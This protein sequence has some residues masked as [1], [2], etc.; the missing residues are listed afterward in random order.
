M[1]FGQ[2]FQI[3]PIQVATLVSSAVN[4]G[5]RITP[6]LGTRIIDEEGETVEEF[7]YA[8]ET[9][10]SEQTSESM[11]EL[12]ES[13][14]AEGGGKNAVI[15]GYEIGGKTATSQTLPR[16]AYKYISSFVGFAPADNP[17]VLGLCIIYHPQGVYYGGTIAAPVIRTIFENILPYL[18]IEKTGN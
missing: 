8:S 13:V 9:V 1:S 4:G 2:S 16:S 17:Q 18:G 5:N 11:R 14:V 6:H 15:E 7:T 10:M 12:L 3:T